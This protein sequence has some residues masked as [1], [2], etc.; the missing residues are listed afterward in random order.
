M[1]V[2]NVSFSVDQ[3]EWVSIIGPNGAGKTTLFNLIAGVFKPT[4]GTVRFEG[5]AIHHLGVAS[6]VRV[7]IARTFQ[8]ARPFPSLSVR[9]NVLLAAGHAQTRALG[10]A[11][12]PRWRAPEA[13]RATDRILERVGLSQQAADSASTLNVSGLR[14][15]EIARALALDPKLL[16]LD[17]PAAGLGAERIADLAGLVTDLHREGRTI[18]LVEHHVGFA[19]SRCD[20]AIVLDQGSLLAQGSPDAIRNDARVI[21]AYLGDEGGDA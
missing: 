16:L 11:L 3:G 12:R 5:R 4:A 15:L 13:E 7:G 21:S 1:A 17:E 20:R 19:L 18:L 6:R 2:E 8:I 10:R 14:R 9:D